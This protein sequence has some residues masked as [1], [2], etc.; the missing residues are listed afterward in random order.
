M[1]IHDSETGES[2]A[3]LI[4]QRGQDDDPDNRL[5][6][7]HLVEHMLFLGTDEDP[8]PSGFQT[9]LSNTGGGYDATTTSSAT[10]FEFSSQPAV[11]EEALSRFSRFFV[12]PTLDP[13][14]IGQERKAVH[15]EFLLHASNPTSRLEAVRRATMN[16]AHPSSRL[17]MGNTETLADRPGDPVHDDVTTFFERYYSADA[18][19]LAVL[20]DAPVETL[21]EWVE[22]EFAEIPVRDAPTAP[23]PP[24]FLDDQ[25]G[26]RIDTATEGERYLEL[27]F[28]VDAEQA[29]W[30][31]RTHTHVL[32]ILDDE[33]DGSLAHRLREAGW[34]TSIETQRLNATD[35]VEL[36]TLGFRLTEAGASHIDAITAASFAAIAQIDDDRSAAL[37]AD[38]KRRLELDFRYD[39]PDDAGPSVRFAAE[40]LAAPIGDSHLL[41]HWATLAPFDAARV[42]E[43]TLARIGV[44]NLRM[45]VAL[46]EGEGATVLDQTEPVFGTQFAVRA[47]TETE[48]RTFAGGAP[49]DLSLPPPNPYFPEDLSLVSEEASI[50]APVRVDEAPLELYYC[51]DT[52][53]GLPHA[54]VRLELFLDASRY[55]PARR[56]V[57]TLLQQRMLAD[58][59]RG[60]G[61]TTADA[62]LQYDLDVTNTR[63][64]L[65]TYGFDDRMGAFLR[66]LL[67]RIR[68]FDPSDAAFERTRAQIGED[69]SNAG[70]APPYE[71][72]LQ[73]T[74]E[75]LDPN[76]AGFD[77]LLPI[78][79][80]L[81]ADDLRAH[82]T[83]TFARAHARMLAQG[84]VTEADALRWAETVHRIALADAAPLSTATVGRYTLPDGVEVVRDVAIDHDESSVVVSYLNAEPSLPDEAVWSVVATLVETPF[85]NEM[86]TNQ[87]LGYVVGSSYSPEDVLPGMYF[88]IQSPAAGPVTLLERIDTFLREM[89]SA[90]E[91]IPEETVRAAASAL[92]AQQRATGRDL[93]TRGYV[94]SQM[95]DLGYPLFDREAQLASHLD[96]VTREDVIALWRRLARKEAGRLVVRS[97]GRAHEE[98]RDDACPDEACAVREL[99]L[100]TRDPR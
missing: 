60:F 81:T 24:A 66:D 40:A 47:F 54:F 67:L 12:A 46:P 33:T 34:I 69:W 19:T 23:S 9:F 32:R 28:P 1:V 68:E 10:S 84:N 6:I 77:I 100:F 4:V 36:F 52:Y 83:A 73:A 25:L 58:H 22:R 92:A 26:V 31:H 39:T 48:A 62:G 5:G 96:A 29:M 45:I 90:I 70:S 11:F 56:Q 78:L 16:P 64:A 59:L 85:F 82:H 8:D 3:T 44:D 75:I 63:I 61:S 53:G 41:D 17:G 2:A 80:N 18:M 14:R 87:Q 50:A 91:H 38:W 93:L 89:E 27:H 95:L 20:S 13:E 99:D 94:H 42:R 35:D 72:T 57:L 55:T 65:T 86:R 7:A 74:A 49:F 37:Y 15:A 79:D 71:Q 43:A 97:F 51:R 98:E 30:P 21:R 88:V 76:D